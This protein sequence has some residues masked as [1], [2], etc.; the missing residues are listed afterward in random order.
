[1]DAAALGTKS[2][3]CITGFH[4]I[5]LLMGRG[6]RWSRYKILSLHCRISL[7]QLAY[8]QR[9]SLVSV[10]NFFISLRNFTRSACLWVEDVAGLGTKFL[11]FITKFHSISLGLGGERTKLYINVIFRLD[12]SWS[13]DFVRNEQNSTETSYCSFFSNFFFAFFSSTSISPLINASFFA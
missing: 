4:S 9:M 3:H 2:F 11:H 7:D 12:S 5:S 10:Q 8:G 6:C 13:S 1:M